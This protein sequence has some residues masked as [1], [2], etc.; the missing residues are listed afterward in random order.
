MS[1]R[2]EKGW[3]VFHHA[4][5]NNRPVFIEKIITKAKEPRTK[6]R[7]KK[8]AKQKQVLLELDDLTYADESP[9]MLYGPYLT[10]DT[11]Q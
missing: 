8:L 1:L 2:D 10:V 5:Y 11:F 3:N 9:L 4:L 7:V 6:E